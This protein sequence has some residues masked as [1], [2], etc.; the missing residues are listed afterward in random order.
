[1]KRVP[2]ALAVAVMLAAGPARAGEDPL[3]PERIEWSALPNLAWIDDYG[4]ILGGNAMMA[5]F[6]PRHDPY[7]WRIYVVVS[8]SLKKWREKIDVVQQRYY[9]DLDFPDVIEDRLWLHAHAEFFSIP[10]AGWY[11]IGQ[12]AAYDPPPGSSGT[13]YRFERIMPW[14]QVDAR[15][16]LAGGWEILFGLGFHYMQISTY[17]GS[18]LDEDASLGLPGRE[19]PLPGLEKHALVELAAGIQLDTRDNRHNPLGGRYHQLALRWSPGPLTGTDHH[20]GGVTAFLSWFEP[21]AGPALLL[22]ARVYADMLFG[23]PP[24]YEM[25][26]AGAFPFIDMPGGSRAIRGV[27]VGRLHGGVKLMA[28]VELRSFFWRFSLGK[29]RFVVGAA[30]FFDVGRVWSW[31]GRWDEHDDTPRVLAFGTGAGLRIQWGETFLIRL[32]AAYSPEAGEGD[33]PIALY[34]DAS[35]HF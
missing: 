34:F 3:D 27:P 29:H 14:A 10:T 22:A 33:V 8:F 12:S 23:D 7:E 24:F 4:L 15:L 28:N 21:I 1:M 25:S 2:A 19:G 31:W 11:G 16:Q 18:K 30:A 20:F 9:V 5:R 17:R 13:Y 6:S 32:D 35:H 26:F